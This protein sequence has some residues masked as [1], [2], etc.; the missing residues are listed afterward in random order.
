MKGRV[1]GV[2]FRFF[3][4]RAARRHGLDGWVRNL[5]DGGVEALAQGEPASLEAFGTE[6]RRGPAGARVA[7]VEEAEAAVDEGLEGFDVRF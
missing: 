5:H 1:Q 3:A 7:S 4:V 6:L 2:G